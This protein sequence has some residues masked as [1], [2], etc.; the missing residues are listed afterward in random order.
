M[1]EMFFENFANRC[2]LGVACCA[3]YHDETI[4]ETRAIS[5]SETPIR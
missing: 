3:Y 1:R 2:E 4:S 5:H